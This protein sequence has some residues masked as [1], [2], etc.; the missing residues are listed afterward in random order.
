MHPWWHTVWLAIQAEFADIAD[1]RE[2]TQ[3]WCA[4]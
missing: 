2:V 3:I 4:C 1:L